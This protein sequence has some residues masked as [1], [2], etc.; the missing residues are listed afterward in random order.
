MWPFHCRMVVT[1]CV[2]E[3][4]MQCQDCMRF[5]F[6][7]CVF[8]WKL[9][10]SGLWS[11]LSGHLINR[12]WQWTALIRRDDTC[13]QINAHWCVC[14]CVFWMRTC[15]KQVIWSHMLDCCKGKICCSAGI[16]WMV[17]RLVVLLCTALWRVVNLCHLGTIGYTYCSLCMCL[18]HLEYTIS[19]H[20]W[21]TDESFFIEWI[22]VVRCLYPCTSFLHREI[23]TS[24]FPHLRSSFTR[25]T[26]RPVFP[27]FAL[28]LCQ[29]LPHAT[30]FPTEAGS[31]RAC[32]VPALVLLWEWLTSP[33]SQVILWDTSTLSHAMIYHTHQTSN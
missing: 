12:L 32:P 11:S 10:L 15:R 23:F 17:T 22:S 16:F 4:H 20:E 7:V 13:L 6:S 8:L 21:V 2:D 33:F 19:L 5:Y 9:K 31:R 30:R 18:W 29:I 28:T 24:V 1:V 14:V 26:C 25:Y 3:K 27:Y